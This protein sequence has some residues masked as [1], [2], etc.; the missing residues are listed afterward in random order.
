MKNSNSVNPHLFYGV[1]TAGIVVV[2]ALFFHLSS[3]IPFVLAIFFGVNLASIM[4]MGLD[5]SLARSSSL[6]IPEVVLYLQALVGGA[7]GILLGIHIF[8]HKTRKASFQFVLLLI[9]TAQVALFRL[10]DVDV[11]PERP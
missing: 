1:F 4:S 2:A 8:K 6:R 7:P 5:K 11:R 3:S 9:V 10:L